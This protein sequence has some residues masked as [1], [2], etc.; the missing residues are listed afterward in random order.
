[1]RFMSKALELNQIL[2]KISKYAKSDTI[3]D[4]II[5]LEP[6]TDQDSIESALTETL[7]MTTLIVR[8]GVMPFLEDYDIH[9]L[10]KYAS[11]DRSF[12]IQELLY[13]R[14]FLLMER[15]I[16]KYNRELERIKISTL[17]LTRYFQ[18][19]HSH[20]SLLEYIQSKMD[21]DGQILDSATPEL[22]HIRK[23][24]SRF[25]KQL[26]DKL[27]KLLVDYS[28]YLNESVI[29][30]RN[31]RFCL[32]VKDAFKNKFKG[33]VHDMSAS[34]QTVYIE[35]EATRQITAQ[36]EQ[37]KV[38]EEKEIQKIV[39]LMSEEVHHAYAS[40]KDNLDL[41]LTLDFIQSKALYARTINANKPSTN[42]KGTILLMKAKHPLLDQ[43]TAVPISLELNEEMKTLLITGPN[44]G[45]KTVALKTVG[46]LTLMTQCGLLIP[47]NETSNIAIFDQ[48]FAD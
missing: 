6:M 12:S 36:I 21:E 9:E 5:N 17:S 33:I 18:A 44:T 30:I 10:L 48:I 14:L 25:D 39:S 31:D 13:V 26:Q 15:D 34:K 47:A 41:F 4:E 3:R 35:P 29:V 16:I 32:P 45:G 19:I 2:D 20:A 22:M 27:Q 42:T 28:P 43:A 38:Q 7:D 40:L 23:D 11:L 8:S 1:M 46:L 24:L 37:L